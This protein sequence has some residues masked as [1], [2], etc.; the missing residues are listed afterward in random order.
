MSDKIASS[1]WFEQFKT[2]NKNVNPSNVESSS[3]AQIVKDFTI[4]STDKNDFVDLPILSI[5]V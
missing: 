4:W 2:L 5:E 1:A 3:E